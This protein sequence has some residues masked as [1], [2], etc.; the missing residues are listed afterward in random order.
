MPR[1][2]VML[3][4]RYDKMNVMPNLCQMSKEA[5]IDV[6]LSKCQV[7]TYQSCLYL[8]LDQKTVLCAFEKKN[9]AIPKKERQSSNFETPGILGERTLRFVLFCIKVL[10]LPKS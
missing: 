2:E 5:N 8:I 1:K 10:F 3:G 6:N 4:P 9:M 7:R